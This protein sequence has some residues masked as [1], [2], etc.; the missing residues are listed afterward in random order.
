MVFSILNKYIDYMAVK[1]SVANETLYLEIDNG[2]KA[3]IEKVMQDWH[4]K[5]MESFLRFFVSVATESYD[6]K[7]VA[8]INQDSIL[9]KA[10][11]AD[12]LLEQADEKR[13]KFDFNTNNSIKSE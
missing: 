2:D 1:S 8:F 12:H 7:T 11:P 3:K 13:E 10:L 5:N 9:Q 6:K 4:F